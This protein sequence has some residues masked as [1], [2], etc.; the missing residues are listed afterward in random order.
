MNAY[1][2]EC[3]IVKA[4]QEV[5]KSMIMQWA[6]DTQKTAVEKTLT[7]ESMIKRG[8]KNA[9]GIAPLEK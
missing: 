2:A 1:Q 6:Q 3:H 9:T 7:D 8:K 5:G 4:V